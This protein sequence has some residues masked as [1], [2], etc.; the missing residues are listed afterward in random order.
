MGPPSQPARCC[1]HAVLRWLV[2]LS[3]SL[4]SGFSPLIKTAPPPPPKTCT[5]EQQS[6][7]LLFPP[8]QRPTSLLYKGPGIWVFEQPFYTTTNIKVRGEQ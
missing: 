8:T 6:L 2:L 4:A 7:P 3:A 5:P 1:Q